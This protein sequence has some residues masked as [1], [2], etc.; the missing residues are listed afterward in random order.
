M[1]RNSAITSLVAA[2]AL[3]AWMDGATAGVGDP[4][5]GTDHV[6]YPGELSCS[7]FERLAATQANLYHHVTGKRV[8]TDEDKALAAWLWRNTHYWHGEEGAQDLWDQGFTKGGDLWTR[9]YWTG[10]YAHGFALCGTTHSQW[11]AEF[12]ALLGHNRGRAVGTKGHNAFEAFLQGGPYA[13]GKWVLLD[14]DLST[15]VFDPAGKALLSIPEVKNNLKQLT[16]V[17]FKPERQ[18]GWPICG[19]HPG[20]AASYDGYSVAEYLS[21]YSGVLPIVHL[22][23]GEKLRRYL[24]PGLGNLTD[25]DT[26][27]FWGRNY[28]TAGIPGPE[29]SRTWVNQPERMHGNLAG[30]G[31]NEGQARYANAVYTYEPDFASGDYREGVID[32]GENHVTFEFYTPYIIAATPPND[33]PWGIYDEGCRNG[34]VLHG[35]LPGAVAVSTDQ[36]ATWQDAGEFR[37]GMDLTDAVKGHRQYLLRIG[38]GAKQLAEKRLVVITAC[39]M[40]SSVVPRLRDV[41]STVTFQASNRAVVSAGP[42]R[43]QA[44]AHV[45]AG[46]MGTPRVTLELRTPRGEPARAIYA[47]AHVQSGSPPSSDVKY[48]IEYSSDAGKTWKP[49]VK[50]WTITRRGDEPQDFWSQSFCWGDAQIAD[51][52][53][54]AVQVR[55]RNDGGKAYARCEAHLVYQTAAKDRT[56]VTFSWNNATGPRRASHTFA[57]SADSEDRKT[58]EIPTGEKVDTRWVEIQPLQDK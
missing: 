35:H 41:S 23:R 52:S 57:A 53:V 47:A 44:A 2:V 7:T 19:L 39:Q 50:D 43:D 33:E 31:Y 37:S 22:R 54:E 12:N 36:G 55:F 16:D 25:G 56:H 10:L 11:T 45:V 26:F 46:Q 5:I 14:H 4:Q 28:N 8:K 42:N 40:N 27:V 9:D 3:L 13:D 17:T 34:L 15:V 51:S 18:R 20:D 24:K 21:G 38:S 49:V 48:Q 6:W 1:F 30:A 29:R 32:E 58:W